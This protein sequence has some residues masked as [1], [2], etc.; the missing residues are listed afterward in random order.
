VSRTWAVS[1]GETERM[2]L[3][4]IIMDSDPGS[5]LE[6]LKEVVY[7]KVKEAE[8]PGSCFHDIAKPVDNVG[9]PINRHKDLGSS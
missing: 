3:E 7:P 9:R 4:R 2:D 5:A 6:F 8:K 1:F